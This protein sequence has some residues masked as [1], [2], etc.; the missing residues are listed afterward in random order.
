MAD[1]ARVIVRPAV[2]RVD[3]WYRVL[4]GHTVGCCAC[5]AG[6]DCSGARRLRRKWKRSR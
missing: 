1:V 4:I 2:P 6:T 5:R 3:H